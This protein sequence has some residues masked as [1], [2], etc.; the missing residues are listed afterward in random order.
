ME[1]QLT[2]KVDRKSLGIVFRS[3]IHTEEF[4]KLSPTQQSEFFEAQIK[5]FISTHVEVNIEIVKD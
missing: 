1:Y 5:Q 4:K 2:L 3:Y